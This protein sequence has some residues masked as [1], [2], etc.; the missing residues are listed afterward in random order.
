MA[1]IEKS[2][3]KNVQDDLLNVGTEPNALA[4]PD[5]YC[6]VD[7]DV[8]S[9]DLRMPVMNA[10]SA[11]SQ[12][13]INDGVGAQGD[14][15]FRGFVV[16]NVSNPVEIIVLKVKKYFK[17]NLPYGSDERPQIF[18]SVQEY[19]NAGFVKKD[20]VRVADILFLAK[21]PEKP[22]S[23]S[24]TDEDLDMLFGI[25][26]MGGKW[27]AGKIIAQKSNYNLCAIPLFTFYGIANP[28]NGFLEHRIRIGSDVLTNQKNKYTVLK[29]MVQS[30]KVEGQLEELKSSGLLSLIQG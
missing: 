14:I 25:D 27:A 3:D 4:K 24:T 10:W 11:S 18:N 9:S 16:G 20:I 29:S 1:K 15:L 19:V 21:R 2:E 12:V 28:P 13:F 8:D 26:F 7:G 6:A 23:A 30:K 17:E 22:C 5:Q